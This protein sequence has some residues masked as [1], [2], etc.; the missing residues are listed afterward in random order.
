MNKSAI[1]KIV[2]VGGGTA[3][4]M[5]AACLAKVLDGLNYQITLVES[6]EIPTVGVGEATIPP[7]V[8][9]IRFLGINEQEFVRATNATFKLGIQFEGWRTNDSRYFHQFGALGCAIDGLPFYHFWLRAK[10]QGDQTVLSQF[11]PA[12]RMAAQNKFV[13]ASFGSQ[14]SLL[15]GSSHAW[16]F[17]ASLVAKYFSEYA[18]QKGVTRIEA[19]VLETTLDDASDIASLRLEAA[20]GVSTLEGDLFID[21]TGFQGLLIEQALGAGYQDWTEFLTCDRAVAIQ[22]ESVGQITPYTRAIA[23]PAGW[24]WRI[25]LQTRV[26]NGYVYCSQF[27]DQ[28]DAQAHLLSQIDGKPVT[29]PKHLRFVTGHRRSIWK[30]NCVAIGLSAGFLEPLESTGIHLIMRGIRRLIELLPAT[31]DCAAQ[32]QEYNQSLIAEYTA[33]RDFLVLHYATTQRDDTPFWRHCGAISIP[34]SL[35]HKL[36]LFKASGY[37]KPESHD[38]FEYSNWLA[39]L[40]GMGVRAEHTN[41]RINSVAPE[42]AAKILQ[43]LDAALGK[44][45]DAAPSHEAFIQRYVIDNKL[46]KQKAG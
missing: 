4:W 8:D 15:A 34:E 7:I 18:Q 35:A 1:R 44:M 10:Q 12:A 45:S 28:D 3:G 30:Q 22:S 31:R 41:P 23:E 39:V 13:P 21:C 38:L 46:E 26:G 11:S 5:S 2:I 36:A 6:A 37:L 43:Q 16:H 32:A 42:E 27:L 19:N 24:R 20:T 9:F 29:E 14:D 17:D 25:P 33:I 40:E